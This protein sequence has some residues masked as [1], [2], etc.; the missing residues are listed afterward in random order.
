MEIIDGYGGIFG[1][2]DGGGFDMDKWRGY[3][4][5]VYPGLREKV[6]N[7]FARVKAAGSNEKM[8]AVLNSPFEKTDLAQTAHSAFLAVTEHLPEKIKNTFGTDLEVTVILYLGL[9]N[10]AGWAT[11]IGGKKVVLIGLEKVVE[12]GWVS[13]EDMVALIY[14][15]LGHIWHFLFE[16]KKRMY[17]KKERALRQLY[18]EGV[19]MVFEQTLCGDS[20]FYHQNKDGWLDWCRSNEKRIK[21]EFLKRLESGCSVQD[22][23]GDWCSFMGHSDVGYYLGAAFVRYIMKTHS[24]AETAKM[25]IGEVKKQFYS[26]A[27]ADG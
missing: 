7:D 27:N 6:E 10:A 18:R 5:S 17:T 24:F 3:A 13:E 8:I 21:Q 1:V 16:R 22:F 15:E 9:S 11:E 23:F 19:A 26:F 25:K 20:G 2:Y 4:E 14:H 12:L